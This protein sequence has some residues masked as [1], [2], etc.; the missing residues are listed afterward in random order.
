MPDCAI[1]HHDGCEEGTGRDRICREARHRADLDLRRC[2]DAEKAG[3]RRWRA[4]LRGLA[5]RR[6]IPTTSIVRRLS[7][8]RPGTTGRAEGRA[9]LGAWACC[10]SSAACWAPIG[11]LVREG[12]R[13]VAALPLFHSY[14]LEP[15][16]CSACL[17]VGAQRAHHGDSSRRNKRLICCRPGSTRSLPGVPT[18]FHYLLLRAQEIGRRAARSASGS[19]SRRAPSCRRPCNKA[20]EERFQDATSRWIRHHRDVDRW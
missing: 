7:S 5:R 19:A 10:G 4:S 15:V 8:T 1:R 17:A 13:A 14:G 20:F 16:R 6:P 18:M 2:Q 3:R 12:R 11:E 9:A